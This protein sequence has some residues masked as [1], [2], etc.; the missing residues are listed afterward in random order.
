MMQNVMKF[1]EIC[2]M[3]THHIATDFQLSMVGPIVAVA[4]LKFPKMTGGVVVGGN[5]VMAVVRF[6]RAW[7]E[8]LSVF[9]TEG[10]R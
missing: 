2:M 4:I 8:G 6:Y 5:L 7:F 9:V 3:H 10:R 1:E